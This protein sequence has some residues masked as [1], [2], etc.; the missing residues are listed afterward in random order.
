MA[1]NRKLTEA[2]L[3]IGY[4]VWKGF[5][6]MSSSP[7]LARIMKR[8]GTHDGAFHC[9]EALACFMLMQM[10]EYVDAEII[11]TRDEEKLKTCD[12]VV[13]VGGV[14]DPETLRFDHHQRDF[15]DTFSSILPH[16]K[17]KNIKLSS[18]GLIYA[19]F[20]V[21]VIATILKTKN[22]QANSECLQSLYKVVYD[23]F[24]EEIDAV[25][26]GVPMCES[27][28]TSYRINTHLSARVSRLNP[29]WNEDGKD[30]DERFKKAMALAGNEFV[31][32]VV[33]IV[34]T[35]WPARE[36]VMSAI[37]TRLMVHE[38]GQVIQLPVFCP[39]TD[40]LLS[41]EEDLSLKGE[42]KFVLFEDRNGT[43]RVQAIPIQADSFICRIFLHE[44]W[45]GL[46]DDELCQK[47]K[48]DG[49]IFCHSTGFIGGNK[50]RQ[51]ALKMALE[52]I[53]HQ[54]QSSPSGELM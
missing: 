27:G 39:W 53:R 10:P 18:A 22:I 50:T 1:F 7:K 34:T 54:A 20:G 43:W 25:D 36:N 11:R 17:N 31:E 3:E 45:R 40:H 33:D 6:V 41:L 29:S 5:K 44:D 8:I 47:A 35:W 46:R 14:Y 9:D 37:K 28:K 4:S 42:L 23:R 24:I 48:I 26:N 32:K 30:A 38:S 51:G 52:S 2:T 15:K 19:H 21:Q 16:M 12:I 13:D 49:C